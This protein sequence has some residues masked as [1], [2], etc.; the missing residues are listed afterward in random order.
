MCLCFDMVV[1]SSCGDTAGTG[2]SA[3]VSARFAVGNYVT[4]GTYPQSE[5]GTD[6][7]PIQ[8]MVLDRDGSKALLL[9]RYGLDAQP[10]NT[11]LSEVT[12]ETCS[13]RSWLNNNF[14]NTALI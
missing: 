7:T 5:E 8:W 2:M 12:W 14:R 13:L 4:F 10:Y 11:E 1:L 3:E 9:S 6:A